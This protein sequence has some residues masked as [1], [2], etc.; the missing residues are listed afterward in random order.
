M[1]LMLIAAAAATYKGS[2]SGQNQP[3]A[4]QLLVDK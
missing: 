1:V 2:L 3:F 4:L